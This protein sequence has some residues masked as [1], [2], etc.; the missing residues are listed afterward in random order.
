MMAHRG[1]NQVLSGF[2]VALGKRNQA[3]GG[4]AFVLLLTLIASVVQAEEAKDPAA[5][6]GGS[7]PSICSG[8]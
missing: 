7:I 3:R 5:R 1:G 8:S 6:H 4:A 2:V